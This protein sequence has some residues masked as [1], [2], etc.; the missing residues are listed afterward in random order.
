MKYSYFPGCS[1]STTGISFSESYRFV[2]DKVGIE[3]I[4]IPDWNCCG[5]G[6]TPTEAVSLGLNARNLAL[7]EEANGDMPVMATCAACYGHLKETVHKAR[8]SAES[9]AQINELTGRDWKAEADVVNAIEPFEDPEIQKAIKEA[10]VKP[11]NGLKVACYYGCLLVR[12]KSV[13]GVADDEDP[14]SMEDVLKLVDAEPIDWGHKTLCCGASAQISQPAIGRKLVEEILNNAVANGADAI[15]TACPL[16]WLN[17]D[18]REAE[19]NKQRAAAGKK[20]LNIPVYYFTELMAMAMGGTPAESGL[21]HHFTEAL[22][23]VQRA[24]DTPKVTEEEL[25]AI[26]KAEA[27]AKAARA[28]AEKAVKDADKEAAAERAA[29]KVAAQA[30]SAT[31]TS[32]EVDA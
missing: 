12:P 2:A 10:V 8:E 24:I 27:M 6:H 20:P 16:C 25:K 32:E 29:A 19:V 22:N 30:E 4:D 26:R 14:Q 31:G 1:A 9:L 17:L 13:T 5:A 28:K 23:T 3:L 21:S 11:L 18:M 7:S 15:A